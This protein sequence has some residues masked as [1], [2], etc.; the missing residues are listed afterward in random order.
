[1]SE[2]E[3]TVIRPLPVIVLIDLPNVLPARKADGNKLNKLL[4]LVREIASRSGVVTEK[5]IFC[6]LD[7][8]AG[9]RSQL[10][11]L[12]YQH[13]FQI[14]HCP[15]L[16]PHGKETVD[17]RMLEKMMALSFI[18]PCRF[19]IASQDRDFGAVIPGLQDRG[20]IVEVVTT[21]NKMYGSS[22]GS[23]ADVEYIAPISQVTSETNWDHLRGNCLRDCIQDC[24][25]S[26][27]STIPRTAA[28]PMS[29]EMIL[30][31]TIFCVTRLSDS[32]SLASETGSALF[33]IVQTQLNTH[34]LSGDKLNHGAFFRILKALGSDNLLTVTMGTGSYAK[35]I[36]RVTLNDKHRLYRYLA[37]EFSERLARIMD[38][39]H[40]P[41][42]EASA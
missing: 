13:G 27:L 12:S 23:L 33:Q 35:N 34:G 5:S 25:S 38:H 22:L 2:P 14:M 20:C 4:N 41:K 24:R 18:G 1:M 42:R 21:E 19:I 10:D 31:V 39:R 32:S 16:Q 11:Y 15:R 17:G 40:I 3:Q 28:L 26:L 9:V 29:D 30:L 36:H 6:I 7:D 37:G 8:Y